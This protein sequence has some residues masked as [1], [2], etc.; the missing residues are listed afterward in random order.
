M[1]T[2]FAV[3]IATCYGL[4]IRFFFGFYSNYTEVIS[5][6]LIVLAPVAVGFL[7]VLLAGLK[8][9]TTR[10]GAFFIPWLS[11]LALLIVTIALAMEGMICWI[12]IFPVFAIAAGIGGLM[13]YSLLR[14]RERRDKNQTSD[15]I[16]DD[17]DRNNTLKSSLLL[18]L[19]ML[20]GVV[21]Q[22]R[23]LTPATYTVVSTRHIAASPE[24]VW[25]EL[26]QLPDLQPEEE[27]RF[28]ARVFP[29]PRHLRTELDTLAIGGKR[30]A[31]YERGLFFEE[32]IREITPGKSLTV[33]IKADPGNVPPNVLDEHIVVGG[34]H[35]KALDDTYQIIP[36]PDGTCTLK[37]TGR[38]AIQTPINW[39]AGTWARWLLSD[40]FDALLQV[41]ANRATQPEK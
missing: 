12:M 36:M 31:F 5:I 32:T 14:N 26:V 8:R 28:F 1:K 40:T 13:A 10:G 9:V 16:L 18:L 21:E 23:L 6:S 37:L 4:L 35:F 7:T 41:I 27:H 3:S 22:D 25:A 38:I 30:T 17:F 24:R 29:L 19:P 20:A 33:A 11:S 34:R 39:Y 15:N 2:L